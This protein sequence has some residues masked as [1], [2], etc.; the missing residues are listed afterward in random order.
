[1]N[2]EDRVSGYSMKSKIFNQI[3]IGIVCIFLGFIVAVQ[4][5]MFQASLGDGLAP[6]KRQTELTNELLA[7]K[8]EKTQLI[9]ELDK[10]RD[11]LTEIETSASKD[12]AIIRNL[13]NTV[14]E[15][16][17]LA[18]MTSVKGEGIEVRIENPPVDPAN[19]TETNVISQY[20]EILKMVN[21]LNAAGAEAISINEQR[22][23]GRSEIR[24]AGQYLNVNFV[25]QSLPIVVKA[26]GKK[27]ALEGAL[28]F[29][30][31][32]I[33]H[34]RDVGLLVDIKRLDEVIIPR[35]HGIINFQYAETIEGE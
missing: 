10:V 16:E 12:N 14:R 6:F 20:A 15:Y 18:G 3:A 22:I 9:Q 23:T 2:K 7:L 13:T 19:Y 32:Q 31:G 28:T 25:P 29:R 27:S 4:Y 30:F 33:T 24:A 35:Y 11:S 34:L 1:M 17:L 5:Q 26:I 21:D 8:E